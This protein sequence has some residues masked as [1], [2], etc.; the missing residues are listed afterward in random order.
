M[1]TS[2]SVSRRRGFTVIELSVVNAIVAILFALLL[3]ALQPA[4]EATRQS[5]CY[6]LKQL[7]LVFHKYHNSLND[8]PFGSRVAADILLDKATGNHSCG[9]RLC[10]LRDIV[11]ASL[12]IQTSAINPKYATSSN[13]ATRSALPQRRQVRPGGLGLSESTSLNCKRASGW[14][15]LNS[16]PSERKFI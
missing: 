15:C 5:P 6:S 16:E 9:W 12:N 4:R 2:A 3:P 7:S 13:A 8:L 1:A 14:L 11:P 10:I